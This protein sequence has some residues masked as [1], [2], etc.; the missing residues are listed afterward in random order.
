MLLREVDVA[1]DPSDWSG[2][3]PPAGTVELTMAEDTKVPNTKRRKVPMSPAMNSSTEK[4]S[5]DRRLPVT[6]LMV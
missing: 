2:D 5:L 4:P 1:M 6:L 3:T